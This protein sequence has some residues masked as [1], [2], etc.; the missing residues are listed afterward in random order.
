M[1]VVTTA[2]PPGRRAFA[3]RPALDRVL[4]LN[5]PD[6][7][8]RL[9][10]L[11][12]VV[13]ALLFRIAA[14]MAWQPAV[15]TNWDSGEYLRRAEDGLWVNLHQPMGYALFLRLLHLVTHDLS[16]VIAIQHLIGIACVPLAYAAAR[17]LGAG[18]WTSLIPA[19]AIGLNLDQVY[20]EHAPLSEALFVPLIIVLMWALGRARTSL[21]RRSLAW[22]LALAGAAAAYLVYVRTIGLLILACALV[23]AFVIAARSRRDL[24]A[25]AAFVAVGFGLIGVYMVAQHNAVG[26][27][28]ALIRG[29]GWVHYAEVAPQAD[30]RRFTP[31]PGTRKLCERKPPEERAGQNANFYSFDARSPAFRFAPRGFPTRDEDFEAFADAVE[32]TLPPSKWIGAQVFDDV[33]RGL[34]PSGVG[35][36]SFGYLDP[37]VEKTIREKQDGYFHIP[38]QQLSAP[39]RPLRNMQPYF[40]TSGTMMLFAA[41]ACALALVLVP[42]TRMTILLGAAA[43]GGMWH[44]ADV[45]QRYAVPTHII[46]AIV[47]AVAVGGLTQRWADE[48][49]ERERRRLQPPT[50]G[51]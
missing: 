38:R 10:L 16:G 5:G 48:V 51:W 44:I 7:G 49:A 39:Y 2:S 43:V 31:P 50:G 4:D 37:N 22:W 8:P 30:C 1:P 35:D 19:V 11:A 47:A 12:V 9:A 34:A 41:I 23:G 28:Y 18:R 14:I 17:H 32:P 27:G 29:T 46:G 26:G 24:P 21:D 40:R 25:F 13:V 42:R 36:I 33:V 45:T 3:V 15:L 6:R 20:L